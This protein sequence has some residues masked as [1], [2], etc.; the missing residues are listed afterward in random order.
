MTAALNTPSASIDVQGNY[1]VVQ[2]DN[3]PPTLTIP[4]QVPVEREIFQK[5]QNQFLGTPYTEQTQTQVVSTVADF[6]TA[7]LQQTTAGPSAY[8]FTES[9]NLTYLQIPNSSG[10]LTQSPMNVTFHT[11]ASTTSNIVTTSPGSSNVLTING[12]QYLL[13]AETCNNGISFNVN[14]EVPLTGYNQLVVDPVAMISQK[15]KSNLAV[16]KLRTRTS[17]LKAASAAE[18]KARETLRDIISEEE[19]RRYVVHG[20]ILARGASGKRYQ[21]FG[22]TWK[23]VK[24]FEQGRHLGEL[25]IHT[26]GDCPPTDH[27]INMKILAEVDED[28]LM[29]SGNF[30]P[31]G[32]AA[33]NLNPYIAQN[34]A[35]RIDWNDPQ[36]KKPE[37]SVVNIAEYFKSLKAS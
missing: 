36:L 27:V 17:L 31:N 9:R 28:T 29:K 22:D 1:S 11:G 3:I 35:G 5:L 26:E 16:H 20:F 23:R 2:Q 15:I 6:I 4:P 13:T 7:R 8:L 18:Q 25:C 21:I 24:I 30:Y 32:M 19:W 10:A 12:I 33:E 34:V 37:P 14:Y